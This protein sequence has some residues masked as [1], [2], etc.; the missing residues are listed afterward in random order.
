MLPAARYGGHWTQPADACPDMV[1]VRPAVTSEY[2]PW[3]AY[4]PRP[5]PAA[6]GRWAE[7]IAEAHAEHLA[8]VAAL[9]DHGAVLPDGVTIEGEQPWVVPKLRNALRRLL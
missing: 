9:A 4:S 2:V 8:A 3:P 6:T 5:W 7:E 1:E